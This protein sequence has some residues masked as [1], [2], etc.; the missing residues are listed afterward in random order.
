MIGI[1]T[2]FSTEL[3]EVVGVRSSK[4]IGQESGVQSN[5]FVNQISLLEFTAAV[6]TQANNL[7]CAS[8]VGDLGSFTRIITLNTSHV[9]RSSHKSISLITNR[10]QVTENEQ[11]NGA[12][13]EPADRPDADERTPGS[14][15]KERERGR[16]SIAVSVPGVGSQNVTAQRWLQSSHSNRTFSPASIT[17]RPICSPDPSTHSGHVGFFTPLQASCRPPVTVRP[18]SLGSE[19]SAAIEFR[20]SGARRATSA[21]RP[22]NSR[23]ASTSSSRGLGR[24][25]PS[26]NC[27]SR[28][29]TETRTR[30]TRR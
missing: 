18:T 30:P 10:R 4:G 2:A 27:S 28:T 16:R 15:G 1:K 5:D 29:S 9:T 17:V 22:A 8:D 3:L 23:R 24:T 21:R 6:A 13:S 11:V 20:R 12:A 7:L 25:R 14:G 19:K 26:R